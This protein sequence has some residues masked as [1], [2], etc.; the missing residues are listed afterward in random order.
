MQNNKYF[1]RKSVL[2]K[3]TEEKFFASIAANMEIHNA[4]FDDLL[5]QNGDSKLPHLILISSLSKEH[6]K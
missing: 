5:K 2:T 6:K 4:F 1:W 3:C